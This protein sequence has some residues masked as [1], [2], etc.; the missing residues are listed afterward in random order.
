MHSIAKLLLSTIA[1]IGLSLPGLTASPVQAA[2]NTTL[3]AQ[4]GPCHVSLEGTVTGVISPTEFAIQ[5][6]HVGNIH[7]YDRGARINAHGLTIQRGTF[8]GVYG[9]F[10]QGQR[11]FNAEEV[12]LA[13]SQQVY[14]TYN[15]PTSAVQIGPCHESVFGT[16][17]T[18]RGP[19]A[20]TIGELHT[21]RTLY[22][23]D[24][25]ALMHSNGQS[26]APGTFAGLYGCFERNETV[27]KAEEVTL[28]SSPQT[29]ANMRQTVTLSGVVDEV[30]SG[31]I[32]VRTPHVGHIHV[33]TSQTGFRIGENVTAR[34][35]FDPLS[36]S[37]NATSV[38]VI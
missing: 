23:D 15:R 30:K 21:S 13:P 11:F 24:R 28:A 9:C 25:S 2:A 3:V 36:G 6:P 29:Y 12:T 26:V 38:S 1:I 18:V 8:A 20:F 10:G 33:Y 32:G 22:V 34:G 35:S 19:N 27:F 4:S 7:V 5:A 31:M 17:T 14:A 16:V 37:L